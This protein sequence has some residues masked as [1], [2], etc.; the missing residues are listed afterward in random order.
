MFSN[1]Y[2]KNY[3][4]LRSAEFIKLSQ[5]NLLFGKNNCGKSSVLES[6][7]LISGQ[8]NPTLP[9]TVNNM[10]GIS[11][12]SEQAMTIDFY[13]SDPENKISIV[14]E[15][16]VRRE[17]TVEMIRSDSHDVSLEN[18]H[19][20][21]SDEALLDYGL[22]SH[23]KL[24]G[25]NTQYNSEIRLSKNKSSKGRVG[26]DK[27]YKETLLS[28]FIPSGFL[29]IPI[30][31]KF[32]NIVKNK[33]EGEILETLRIIEP[34]IKDI[35]L[36]GSEIMVDIGMSRRLPINVLGDGIRKLLCIILAI[37]ECANGILIIDEIDNGLHFSV[38][39]NLWSTIFS[40]A[41]RN[42][43]QLFISTHSVDMIKGLADCL[44]EDRQK[45]NRGRVAAYKLIRKENDEVVSLR[46]DYE[47]LSYSINQ[48]MEMR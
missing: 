1:I 4:G 17:L 21:K 6:I 8:S 33:Q 26:I 12:F 15:G 30:T 3:R 31:D 46:Y 2:I 45:E 22:K 19:S 39:K 36:V 32:A 35:Q 9:V 44:S 34:R 23:Y 16:D 14:A 40:A 25:N 13:G 37:F 43:V 11:S 28:Q 18:L 47:S 10:R 7:F 27:R 38:M 24:N 29:Q 48:E 42:N 20:G 41:I 5:I